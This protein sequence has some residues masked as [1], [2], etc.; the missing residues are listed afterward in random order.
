MSNLPAKRTHELGTRPLPLDADRR[1]RATLRARAVEACR[2]TR[3]KK[4]QAQRENRISTLR[5]LLDVVS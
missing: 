2:R 5:K 4:G 3:F 1:R